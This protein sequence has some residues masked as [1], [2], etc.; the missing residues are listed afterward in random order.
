MEYPNL[1][2]KY[3]GL[4]RSLDGYYILNKSENRYKFLSSEK[5]FDEQQL[6]DILNTLKSLNEQH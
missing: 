5:E 6:L 1:E 2:Q 3:E 4:Y